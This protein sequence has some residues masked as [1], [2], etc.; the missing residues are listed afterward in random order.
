MSNVIPLHPAQPL[1]AGYLRV[2]YGD[3][4]RLQHM[5]NVGRLK[6]KRFVFEAAHI[7]SQTE[8]V[9][10]LQ[11]A[12]C[13]IVLDTNFS[14]M[15]FDGKQGSTV[16]KL[17]W[18][19]HDRPWQSA[20]FKILR[21]FDVTRQ[22]AEFAAKHGV[23]SI[24]SPSHVI[25]PDSVDTSSFDRAI[26]ESLRLQ[27]DN[28]NHRDIR[29]DFQLSLATGVLGDQ[30]S[31]YS[32]IAGLAEL[33]I[34]NL[35]LRIENFGATSTGTAVQKVVS[36]TKDFH[37][38]G[39]PI[40]ADYAG[41][42]AGLATLSFGTAGGLC[43]GIGKKETFDLSNWKNKPSSGGG[44]NYVYVAELDKKFKSNQFQLFLDARGSKSKFICNDQECCA[45][46]ND[47]VDR[48]DEHF[49]VQ[50]SKQLQDLA[51]FPADKRAE[52]FLL[53]HVGTAVRMGELST[54]LKIEDEA[55][56]KSLKENKKRLQRL[57]EALMTVA[58]GNLSFSKVPA[59]RGGK[60]RVSAVLVG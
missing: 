38:C 44:S 54:K 19:N 36:F 55:L 42:L 56:K 52:H 16:T 17:P 58:Q 28:L 45:H 6:Y 53:N 12:G 33:P 23:N 29:V 9:K 11:A 48:H 51:K 20:D 59:F 3:Q 5:H 39:K 13:E 35:W 21:N 1:L 41:G 31:R 40:I 25:A 26:C 57:Q 34:D 7:E 47:M 60:N 50:R 46:A 18:A 10:A 24:I 37:D 2:G 15:F 14:E 8:L 30:A 22:I 4:R 43:H 32:L 49:I 27:L